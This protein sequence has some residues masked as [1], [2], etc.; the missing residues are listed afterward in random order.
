MFLDIRSRDRMDFN[1]LDLAIPKIKTP[2]EIEKEM[3]D[4]AKVGNLLGTINLQGCVQNNCCSDG[5]HWDAKDAVCKANNCTATQHWDAA[6]AS[7]VESNC[8]ADKQWDTANAACIPKT[9][10]APK[11]WY[12]ETNTCSD[13]FAT[14]TTAFNSVSIPYKIGEVQKVV[15]PNSPNEF[16]NYT[17]I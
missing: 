17:K 5:T 12:Q 9:C 6:S 15:S 2:S 4:Q 7:C 1:K 10:V 11:R 16:V 8:A 13:T 3:A 14:M